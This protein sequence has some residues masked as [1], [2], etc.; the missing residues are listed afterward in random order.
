MPQLPYGFKRQDII[1]LYSKSKKILRNK[2]S[3][4]YGL[5]SPYRLLVFLVTHFKRSFHR[6]AL[7]PNYLQQLQ[8]L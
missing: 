8:L 3:E 2:N 6:L 4:C 5:S 1:N 7:C